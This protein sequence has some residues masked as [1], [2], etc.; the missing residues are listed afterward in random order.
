MLPVADAPVDPMRAACQEEAQ[1]RCPPCAD[2]GWRHRS[3]RL[4]S[5]V[6]PH[7]FQITGLLLSDYC[8][9]HLR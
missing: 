1:S 2:V 5:L 3:V 8:F 4:P 6:P 7:G 9:Q